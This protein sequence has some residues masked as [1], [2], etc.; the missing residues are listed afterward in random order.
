[1]STE[2]GNFQGRFQII[3]RCA[4]ERLHFHGRF[5]KDT[6]PLNKVQINYIGKSHDN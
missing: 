4:F 3:N 1:M 5:L 2:N 6:E